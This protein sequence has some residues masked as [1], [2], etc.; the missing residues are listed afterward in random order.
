MK[1]Q[2]GILIL[3]TGST[4]RQVVPRLRD[5]GCRV[6]VLSRR[7]RDAGYGIEVMTGDLAKGEGLEAAVDGCTARAAPSATRMRPGPEPGPE[8]GPA[9]VAGPGAAPGVHLHC[10]R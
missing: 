8:P 6:R 9:S 3:V 4:G 2:I 5:A 1:A 7:R 10:R